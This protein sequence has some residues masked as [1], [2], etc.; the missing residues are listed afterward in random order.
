MVQGREEVR[1][2]EQNS[3]ASP[4]FGSLSSQRHPWPFHPTPS[5]RRCSLLLAPQLPAM[6]ENFL[7]AYFI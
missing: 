2:V 4:E 3:A 7:A 1:A 5:V 6:H